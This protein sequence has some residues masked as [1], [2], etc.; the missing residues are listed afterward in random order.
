MN[1]EELNRVLEEHSL[2]LETDGEA[3][4]RADLSGE[5]LS[6]INLR[7]I[8]L[9]N[10][11]LFR[12]CLSDTDLS[13]ACLVGA[14][15]SCAD[16]SRACL[17]A[18]NLENV[19]L[20]GSDLSDT[21]LD[22]A[23]L[24]TADLRNVTLKNACLNSTS[25]RNAYLCFADL[26]G[27]ELKEADLLGT[28]MN[29]ANLSDADLS[30][31]CLKDADLS[32]A[33]L[34]YANLS[35]ANLHG[36]CLELANLRNTCLEDANLDCTCMSNISLKDANLRGASLMDVEMPHADLRNVNLEDACLQDADL[37]DVD[38]RGACLIGVDLTGS[39]LTGAKL[40]DEHL[41]DMELKRNGKGTKVIATRHKRNGIEDPLK[42]KKVLCLDIETTGFGKS[43][44]ILQFAFVSNFGQEREFNRFYRPSYVESWPEAQAVN[45]ISPEDVANEYPFETEENITWI[46]N[47]INEA[48]IIVGHNLKFFDI[49]FIGKYGVDFSGKVIN[50]T[51]NM[52]RQT[53]A[54][55]KSLIACAEHYGYVFNAHDA[56]EDAKAT[57]YCYRRMLEEGIPAI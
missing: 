28:Y 4:R 2:W 40:D 47:A 50:D 35:N 20:R 14:D 21:I 23:C 41:A 24:E 42:D 37:R 46:Q 56:L 10:A 15:L 17:F 13:G 43:D 32:V 6:H 11:N 7:D 55:K 1:I 33:Y 53:K 51:M 38:F 5:L 3:G 44:E 39:V 12:V 34:P 18:T 27:A 52:Y 9:R 19:D 45:N 49:P 31:A 8:D 25:L 48:E 22:H 30:D 57:L 16:L 29:G 26:R 54:K 36:S